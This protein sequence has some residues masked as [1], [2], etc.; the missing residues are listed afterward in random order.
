MTPGDE[1]GDDGISAVRVPTAD[2]RA[3]E[4]PPFVVRSDMPFSIASILS[5]TDD[6]AA[7]RDAAAAATEGAEGG[8]PPRPISATFDRQTPQ[9]PLDVPIGSGCILAAQTLLLQHAPA[10]CC[11]MPA[12]D[13]LQA[14]MLAA[15]RTRECPGPWLQASMKIA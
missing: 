14:R 2:A 10:Q 12:C 1:F 6:A 8:S 5:S 4:G 15:G 9:V 7:E 13:G 3:D 11:P